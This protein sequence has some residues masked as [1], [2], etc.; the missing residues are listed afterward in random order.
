LG[1]GIGGLTAAYLLRNA[2]YQVQI[3]EAQNRAGGR[4]YT[5]RRDYTFTEESPE[6]GTTTQTC[7][8]DKDLYLNMGPGRLPFHHRRVLKYCELL[9]VRL[10]LYVM[11]T[12]A[13]LFQT[14]LAF[15]GK[16]QTRHRI[17]NDTQGYIAELLAKAI[18]K[19]SLDEEL[20][21]VD[22]D[23]LLSLLVDF[24]DLQ[25][26]YTYAGSTRSG[27][28]YP[29]TVEQSCEPESRLSLQYLL[30]SEFWKHR[31]YQPIDFEWQPTL[32]QPVGGMDRIVDGFKNKVG[33]LIE[34]EAEVTGI[35]LVKEAN[36]DSVEVTYQNRNTHQKQ[37]RR[38]D[39]CI[40][41]IPVPLLRAIP[42]NFSDQFTKALNR[43]RFAP[44]CKVGWQANKR[45]WESNENQ[46][47]GGIS[48][49]DDII[50]Q[51]WYPSNDYFSGNG[52]LTG[53][54]NYDQ[55]AIN[56]GKMSLRERLEAARKSAYKLHPEFMNNEIVP[57]DL[58]LSIAWHNVPFQRGGWADWDGSDPAD[59]EAYSQL[60]EPDGHF[61]VVGDQVSPL[62]GWQ[63]GAMMSAEY[64]VEQI[65]A[66]ILRRIKPV[67]PAIRRAPNT[68]EIVQGIF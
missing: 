33:D 41:N 61:Y 25:S 49:I 57:I 38:V 22:R 67:R 11:D 47:Y 54:Y 20:T 60:L 27:C 40:S 52:T 35:R 53:A 29:L 24:G 34:Y 4:S 3:V 28:E 2:D 42:A 10:E 48:Y 63:E 56:L 46:I 31:F 16:P 1:A 17:L 55:D 51:I 19:R 30:S 59:Q 64:V 58:G 44:T 65:A 7:R 39:F 9:G 68:R 12:T 66:T 15:D 18:R 8:F 37:T 26:N 36:K 50:T 14:P 23:K 6:H 13:N 43:A 62:P 45:F 21:E 32:F 5:V